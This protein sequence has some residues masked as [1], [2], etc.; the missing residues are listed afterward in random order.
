MCRRKTLLA[1]LTTFAATSCT[2]EHI[3]G[4]A[5][6]NKSAAGGVAGSSSPGGAAGSSSPGGTAVN[7]ASTGVA[8][9]TPSLAGSNGVNLGGISGAGDSTGAATGGVAT[10]GGGRT[11]GGG[12]G[13]TSTGPGG[14]PSGG[15]AGSAGTYAECAPRTFSAQ[16]SGYSILKSSYLVVPGHLGSGLLGAMGDVEYP[17]GNTSPGVKR[18]IGAVDEALGYAPLVVTWTFDGTGLGDGGTGGV[19]GATGRADPPTLLG[20]YISLNAQVAAKEQLRDEASPTTRTFPN[21]V[22]DLSDLNAPLSGK[23]KEP[24]TKLCYRVRNESA[25]PLIFHFEIKNPLPAIGNPEKLYASSAVSSSQCWQ[26]HCMELSSFED[27]GAFDPSRAKE[28]VLVLDRNDNPPTRGRVSVDEVWFEGPATLSRE[29]LLGK[30]DFEFAEHLMYKASSRM[31]RLASLDPMT[32]GLAQ[33]RDAFGELFSVASQGFLFASLPE[34]I[35]RGWYPRESA[36]RLVRSALEKL[37][38][39]PDSKNV[40]NPPSAGYCKHRGI[41][42]HFLGSDALRKRNF[43]YPD[44]TLDESKNTVELSI[45]DTGLLLLG[46]HVVERYFD[47]TTADEQ[48]IRA[49]ASA[50]RQAAD[51]RWA[52]SFSTGQYFVDWRPLEAGVVPKAPGEW[53]NSMYTS[54]STS[55]YFSGRPGDTVDGAPTSRPFTL[56]YF[57]AESVI[58]NILGLA[59]TD[60]VRPP[61]RLW[62]NWL[63]CSDQGC[64]ASSG[65]MF[66]YQFDRLL[67]L[68]TGAIA[69]PSGTTIAKQSCDVQHAAINAVGATLAL[70]AAHENPYQGYVANAIPE[71]KNPL[72]L[73][74]ASSD[75]GI[76]PYAWAGAFVCD[77]PSIQGSTLSALRTLVQEYPVYSPLTGLA[78]VYY[79]SL[80]DPLSPETRRSRSK[81]LWVNYTAFGIDQGP[82]LL[83]LGQLLCR[84]EGGT[85]QARLATSPV[86]SA[87]LSVAACATGIKDVYE[88]EWGRIADCGR[89]EASESER[90][91]PKLCEVGAPGSVTD[92]FPFRSLSDGRALQIFNQGTVVTYPGIRVAGSTRV[93]LTYS[94]AWPTASAENLKLRVCWGSPASGTCRAINGLEPTTNWDSTREQSAEITIPGVSVCEPRELNIVLDQVPAEAAEWGLQIDRLVVESTS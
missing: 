59:A 19:A 34:M 23:P 57:T 1:L 37:R 78:D 51:W 65:S 81:G 52:Y 4:D 13:G 28:V 39:C 15:Y 55:G 46:A 82:I 41:F 72:L 80:P 64:L 70:P 58:P 48:A 87:G 3:V 31:L 49:A 79:P 77:D 90:C 86:V 40:Q 11:G 20:T 35:D 89:S 22:I 68:N 10:N 93:T 61:N 63:G 7:A 18:E 76:S 83:G 43:D 50:L 54:C 2:N 44:T 88:G 75:G 42:F 5:G 6:T 16:L 17:G 36:A 94:L 45:I 74:Q 73:E 9:R 53:G 21:H 27:T 91:Q 92:N 8:G 24:A 12:D 25:A 62:S 56:D 38:D 67:G 66:V 26:E 30:S 85:C 47:G 29:S 84:L 14:M 71:T 32:Y 69:L 60:D 33:D